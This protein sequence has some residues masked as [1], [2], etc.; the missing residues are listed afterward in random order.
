ML[1]GHGGG[2]PPVGRGPPRGQ[3]APR[4]G[5]NGRL[6]R[7]VA[8]RSAAASGLLQLQCAVELTPELQRRLG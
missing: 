4:A 8:L 1:A 2:Q 6:H 5:T 3:E 7:A